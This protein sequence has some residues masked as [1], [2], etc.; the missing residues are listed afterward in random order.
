MQILHN[1]TSNAIKFTSKGGITFAVQP[2][3]LEEEEKEFN[4]GQRILES[5]EHRG[6]FDTPR[7]ESLAEGLN[8]STLEFLFSVVDTGAG[9]G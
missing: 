4:T 5:C 9:I 1:L 6:G 2:M 7:A 8:N 3:Q